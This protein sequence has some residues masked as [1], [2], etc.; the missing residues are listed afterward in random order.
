MIRVFLKERFSPSLIR[1]AFL[2]FLSC[3]G[4]ALFFLYCYLHFG[5]WDLYFTTVKIG[6]N[7]FTDWH[8]LIPPRGLYEIEWAHV[9]K[10][11]NI[12]RLLTM[13]VILYQF[14]QLC[15]L[16][17]P[18]LRWK[19]RENAIFFKDDAR[20]ALLLTSMLILAG[21]M[22]GRSSYRFAGFGRYL[23]PVIALLQPWCPLPKVQSSTRRII[24]ILILAAFQFFFIAM[25]ARRGW[26][27]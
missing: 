2:T 11:D 16:G 21:S 13:L 24:M 1:A 25:F 6:W 12:G 10:S 5:Q 8:Q 4:M 22:V 19:Q 20:L 26:V 3:G 17:K 18:Y 23:L 27:A 7:E 15:Y 14:F 9:L